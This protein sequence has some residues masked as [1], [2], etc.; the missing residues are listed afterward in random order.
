MKVEIYKLSDEGHPELFKTI[1]VESKRAGAAKREAREAIA[2]EGLYPR[3]INIGEGKIVAYA[4]EY[5]PDARE[6]GKPV[7]H[8]GIVG[9]GRQI[10]RRSAKR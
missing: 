10:R 3:S 4:T 2:R 8:T 7:T 9:G 1:E 5:R 6:R